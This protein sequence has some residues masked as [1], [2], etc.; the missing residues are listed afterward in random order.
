MTKVLKGA[1]AKPEAR[2]ASDRITE[3]LDPNTR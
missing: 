1:E 3:L 2:K